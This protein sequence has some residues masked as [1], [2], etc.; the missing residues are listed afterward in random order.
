MRIKLK[1]VRS[2]ENL[3]SVKS[4]KNV[5]KCFSRVLFFFNHALIFV[6]P[7]NILV[8]LLKERNR[9]EN[10]I[11]KIVLLLFAVGVNAEA[12]NV[13]SRDLGLEKRSTIPGNPGK[14]KAQSRDL[15]KNSTNPEIPEEK[16][17]KVSLLRPVVSSHFLL[18]SKFSGCFFSVFL[19]R[20]P[21]GSFSSP[22]SSRFPLT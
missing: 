7:P 19:F 12:P 2:F 17:E 20:S 14:Y 9:N 6:P 18:R 1:L 16:R 13:Q 5:F 22:V 8:Y 15:R 4:C 3:N 10:R 21:R 11:K